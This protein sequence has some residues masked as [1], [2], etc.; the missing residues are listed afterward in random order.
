MLQRNRTVSYRPRA[1]CYASGEIARAQYYVDGE[2]C[3]RC[4][5]CRRIVRL[6]EHSELVDHLRGEG[7]HSTQLIREAVAS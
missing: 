1:L 2:L 3:G 4:P 5:L 7:Y 6:G